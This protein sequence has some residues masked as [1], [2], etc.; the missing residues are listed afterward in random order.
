MN[1]KNKIQE[2]N[3][4]NSMLNLEEQKNALHSQ[5]RRNDELFLVRLS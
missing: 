2:Q 5:E 4:N 1:N 3:Y